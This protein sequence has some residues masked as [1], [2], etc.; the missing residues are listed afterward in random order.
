MG[1]FIK[2][3]DTH[4]HLG[5]PEYGKEKLTAEAL[6]QEV[7]DNEIVSDVINVGTDLSSSQEAFKISKVYPNVYG[8]VGVHPI[9]A[10]KN[11]IDETTIAALKDMAEY[12]KIVAIGE[13]GLDYHYAK[14]EKEKDLQKQNFIQQIKLSILV[15]KPLVIHCR[16]AWEDLINILRI[17]VSQKARGVIH[18]FT[19]SETHANILL[20]MGF[21]LSFSGI[22]T[23]Q[24]SELLQKII[25]NM[26]LEQILA[27]TD[28]PYLT[29][30]P[31]RGE[32]N[33]PVYVIFIAQK[34]ARLRNMTN[35]QLI[36]QLSDNTRRIFAI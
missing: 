14:E 7:L 29:P 12:K 23:F 27:E 26:P 15:N 34:I 35:E 20:K 22:I 32:I 5:A 10:M 3:V 6:I 24:K 9:Y 11:I 4:C 31:Y 8:T 33:H 1:K 36:S 28:S 16:D 13:C 19:G 17:Y 30:E 25:K 21:Y 18:C 2:L